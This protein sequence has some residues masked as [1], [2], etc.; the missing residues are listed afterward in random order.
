MN[1]R[2]IPGLF[3]SSAAVFA[4]ACGAPPG[5]IGGEGRAPTE[6]VDSE[7]AALTAPITVANSSPMGLVSSTGNLYWTS[8]SLNEFGPDSATV[9]R[10]AKTNVPGQERAIYQEISDGAGFFYFGNIVW[11]LTSDYFGYFVANYRDENGHWTSQIKR[12]SLAGGSATLIATSPAPIGVGELATDGSRLYWTDAAGVRSVALTGGPITTL[13]STPVTHIA[14]DATS[15]YFTQSSAI[16]RLPKGGGASSFV[17]GGQNIVTALSVDAATQLIFW[18][19]RGGAVR[20]SW[21]G[22][23][24]HTYQTLPFSQTS[25]NTDI[26]SVGFD[27]ARVLWTECFG[28]SAGQCKVKV[29]APSH[30]TTLV[31]SAV[32]F[33]GHLQQDRQSLYWGSNTLMK[34]IY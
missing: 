16:N 23:A 15:L 10:G 33:A 32:S 5:D 1:T 28:T 8:Y 18:G 22:N 4:L 31:A 24:P 26:T 6:S 12:V 9:W 20:S 7:A 2:L 30:S 29:Q 21:G 3:I 34:A 11:A 17:I 27:G 25:V 13:V 19:E 14:L